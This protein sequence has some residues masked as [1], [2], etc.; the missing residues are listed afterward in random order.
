MKIY[1]KIKYWLYLIVA[2]LSMYYFKPQIFL[3]SLFDESSMTYYILITA[4]I[5]FDI[6]IVCL[7][8]YLIEEGY[9]KWKLIEM[10][11]KERFCVGCKYKKDDCSHKDWFF[12]DG[13]KCFNKSN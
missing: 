1:K 10:L 13:W 11:E 4:I 3:G 7:I 8:F 6:V 5:F 2:F 12:K 9:R